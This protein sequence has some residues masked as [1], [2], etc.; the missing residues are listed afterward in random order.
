MRITDL[1]TG[2]DY[3]MKI[4]DLN[5]PNEIQRTNHYNLI[6]HEINIPKINIMVQ[7]FSNIS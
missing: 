6:K 1:T 5:E 4:I 7:L 2:I 3:A